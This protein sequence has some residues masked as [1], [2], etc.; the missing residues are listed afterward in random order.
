M[1]AAVM[2][3]CTDFRATQPSIPFNP[4]R[5]SIRHCEP[6]YTSLSISPGPNGEAS[7]G[8]QLPLILMVVLVRFVTAVWPLGNAAHPT[9][10]ALMRATMATAATLE[11]TR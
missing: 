5:S 3:V 2:S 8:V 11:Y 10:E 7:S 4:S 6:R 9:T 1:S